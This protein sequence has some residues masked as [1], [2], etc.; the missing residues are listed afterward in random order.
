MCFYENFQFACE[1]K[2]TDKKVAPYAALLPVFVVY[3]WVNKTNANISGDGMF[4][5]Y[6][7]I[8][9]HYSNKTCIL[10]ERS[11]PGAVKMK[12]CQIFVPLRFLKHHWMSPCAGVNTTVKMS[13]KYTKLL[14]IPS[15]SASLSL[16]LWAHPLCPGLPAVSGPS[17]KA[18]WP[19]LSSHNRNW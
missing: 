8:C 17:L 12:R 3:M 15:P 4:S 11:L 19:L 2:K 16:S 13:C 7:P 18:R 14:H 9:G 10:S 6:S 1:K 5:F